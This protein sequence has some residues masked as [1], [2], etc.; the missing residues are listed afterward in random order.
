MDQ[1][2]T[3]N[4]DE[5]PQYIQNLINKYIILKISWTASISEIDFSLKNESNKCNFIYSRVYKNEVIKNPWEIKKVYF[6][7]AKDQ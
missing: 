2:Y 7:S 5:I 6:H 1:K 3:K 4:T